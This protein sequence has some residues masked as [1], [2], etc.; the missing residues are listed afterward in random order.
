MYI[1]PLLLCLLLT[2]TLSLNCKYII[3]P[4]DLHGN[5]NISKK[6]DV[7]NIC[8]ER[9]QQNIHFLWMKSMTQILQTS[10][11]QNTSLQSVHLF[12]WLLIMKWYDICYESSNIQNLQSPCG[13]INIESLEASK[14]WYI[15]VPD[16]YIVNITLKEAYTK[17]SD[18]CSDTNIAVF[19]GISIGHRLIAEFCG[20]VL[21]ETMYTLENTGVIHMITH[22]YSGYLR[23]DFQVGLNGLAFRFNGTIFN[24]PNYWNITAPN[25]PL[26]VYYLYNVLQYMWYYTPPSPNHFYQ[27]VNVPAPDDSPPT[28][29]IGM[30]YKPLSLFITTFACRNQHSFITLANGVLPLQLLSQHPKSL[31]CKQ[32]TPYNVTIMDHKFIS[33]LLALH[34]LEQEVFVNLYFRQDHYNITN[35]YRVFDASIFPHFTERSSVMQYPKPF[36]LCLFIPNHAGTITLKN[37]KY[38]GLKRNMQHTHIFSI[39]QDE[40][41][42]NGHYE[43]PK[44]K[45]C[46]KSISFKS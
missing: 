21:F 5:A 26:W 18:A 43:F 20:Y 46:L 16:N 33:V 37:F 35:T 15:Q 38:H 11:L 14:T 1:T 10:G 19:H 22:W 29:H 2:T 6:L 45:H 13:S 24:S 39:R 44:G 25:K 3:E 17:Y 42:E 27:K 40:N 36:V 12:V 30:Q 34:I 8:G 9:L 28:Q 32:M 4:Y 31:R 23:A 7:L 41:D